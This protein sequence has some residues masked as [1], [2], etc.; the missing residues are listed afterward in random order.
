MLMLHDLLNPQAPVAAGRTYATP[1]ERAKAS[2]IEQVHGGTYDL[3]WQFESAVKTA[4]VLG[5]GKR[6]DLLL[7]RPR[8]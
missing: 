8:R 2:H 7:R 1:L 5:L 6:P 4:A 3:P